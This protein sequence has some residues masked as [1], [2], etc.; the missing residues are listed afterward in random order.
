MNCNENELKRGK[1][2]N[3]NSNREKKERVTRAR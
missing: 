3:N 2:N 1:I